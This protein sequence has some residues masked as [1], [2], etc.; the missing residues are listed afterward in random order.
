MV[1]ICGPRL[2]TDELKVPEE[3]EVKGYVPALYEHFAA[4]DLAIVQGGG[5]TT[6]ELTAL[7]RPFLYFP[8]AMHCEQQ[9][10]VAGRL[11]RHQAGIK[12][13]YSQTTANILADM[14]IANLGKEVNYNPIPVNG[15]Q[16]ATQFI[17]ELL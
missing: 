9:I 1:L 12:M 11:A 10:H 15:A 4:S 14:V 5:T 16:K 3:I 2:A 6:I 13:V 8:L 17:S 7:N